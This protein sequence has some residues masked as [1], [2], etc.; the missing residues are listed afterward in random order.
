MA[1]RI[2]GYPEA[3]KD[4]QSDGCP[5]LSVS[6]ENLQ[7]WNVEIYINGNLIA[8]QMCSAEKAD[9]EIE[10]LEQDIIDTIAETWGL[11]VG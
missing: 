7:C 2:S 8:I 4:Y 3:L 1:E 6:R 10:I 5:E 9:D 11:E